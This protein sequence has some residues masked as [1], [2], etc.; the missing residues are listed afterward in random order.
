MHTLER[1]KK[2]TPHSH[3][4]MASLTLITAQ[5]AQK[6]TLDTWSNSGPEKVDDLPKPHSD[7][8]LEP[9]SQ[10]SAPLAHSAGSPGGSGGVSTEWRKLWIWGS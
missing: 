4:A 3:P 6:V 1:L 8:V 10:S 2:P 7:L 5:E 9:D